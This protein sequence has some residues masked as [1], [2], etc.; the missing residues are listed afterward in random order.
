MKLVLASY[1]QPENHGPGRKIGIS[2][3]KPKEIECELKFDPLS[4]EQLYWDYHKYKK[5]DPDM[6]GKAFNKAFRE[7]LDGFFET[8]Q[9][10]SAAQNKSVFEL[11]PFQEGDT[12]LS[13]EHKGHLTYRSIVAEYLRKVGYEVE[14]N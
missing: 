8:V 5:D 10:D 11:L 14:E 9:K 12:L 3:S 7:K 4:P 6:A 1:F 2:P 13:F